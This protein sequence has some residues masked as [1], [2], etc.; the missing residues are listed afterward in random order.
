M[1]RMTEDRQERVDPHLLCSEVKKLLGCDIQPASQQDIEDEP[2]FL[3]FLSAKAIEH[4]TV[5]EKAL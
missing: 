1:K 5:F 3:H 4:L 2:P